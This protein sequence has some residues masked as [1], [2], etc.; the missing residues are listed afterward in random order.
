MSREQTETYD[1]P[2]W[3]IMTCKNE[4]LHWPLYVIFLTAISLLNSVILK[5][6]FTVIQ[7]IEAIKG[8]MLK[9]MNTF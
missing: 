5:N 9:A 2:W 8:K 1:W 7:L 4:N 6:V 3:I